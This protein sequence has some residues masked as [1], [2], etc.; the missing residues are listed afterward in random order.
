[1]V[2][3]EKDEYWKIADGELT[4]DQ[5]AVE[6]EEILVEPGET[7]KLF[8]RKDRHLVQLFWNAKPAPA[9][10]YFRVEKSADGITY[11]VAG[12]VR[13][14]QNNADIIQH[15]FTDHSP[16]SAV[17]WYRL[18]QRKPTGEFA[19]YGTPIKVKGNG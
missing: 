14:G 12:L 15:S 4:A 2:C 13:S 11:D 16:F 18:L 3:D 6:G 9:E 10:Q 5:L 1:M 8:A 17:T 19:P 7:G